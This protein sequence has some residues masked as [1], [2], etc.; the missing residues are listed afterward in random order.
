[1]LDGEHDL[2]GGAAQVDEADQCSL[3][4]QDLGEPDAGL[5][6]QKAPVVAYAQASLGAALPLHSAGEG[7]RDALNV[8]LD[9]AVADHGAPA[10]GAE[11]DHPV[12]LLP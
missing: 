5:P 1:M 11:F 6:A 10:A 9:K 8:F 2:R 4:R 12:C 3:A 7:G